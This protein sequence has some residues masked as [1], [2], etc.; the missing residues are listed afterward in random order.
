MGADKLAKNT[1]IAAKLISPQ[2]FVIS[3]IKASLGVLSPCFV[4]YDELFT[5]IR[6]PSFEEL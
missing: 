3:I 4:Y 5:C 1:P 6:A 2:K